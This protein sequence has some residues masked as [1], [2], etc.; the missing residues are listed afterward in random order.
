MRNSIPHPSSVKNGVGAKVSAVSCAICQTLEVRSLP[1]ARF[2]EDI[3]QAYMEILII[4]L[5]R[6][7]VLAIPSEPQSV[8]VNRQCAAVRR[9]ID[10]HFKESLTLDLLAEI[11]HMNKFYLAHAFKQEF[12]ISPINYM[13]TKRI[14]ES[15]FMLAE[16][17]LSM[18]QIAQM[19]GFSSP[20]YFSQVFSR[21]QSISPR[22]YRQRLNH[23]Q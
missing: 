6:T 23:A 18:S 11:A 4:R 13:L 20:S 22:E 2:Y 17:D 15:K 19:L 14:E 8:S 9:Y 1:R 5:M 10:Q 3:Y 16:T 7:T 12:D 21:T